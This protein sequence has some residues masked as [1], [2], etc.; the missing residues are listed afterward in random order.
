MRISIM[1][2]PSG[3]Y[4]NS[5]DGEKSYVRKINTPASPVSAHANSR[6]RETKEE[7]KGTVN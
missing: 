6:R 2:A 5:G 3:Y 7:M 1:P 4:V